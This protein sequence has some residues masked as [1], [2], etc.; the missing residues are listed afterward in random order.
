MLFKSAHF[1]C[2][3]SSDSPGK[4]GALKRRLSTSWAFGGTK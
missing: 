3:E 1:G 2:T 4:L